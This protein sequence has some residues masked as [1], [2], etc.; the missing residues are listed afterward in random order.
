[1]CLE[2]GESHEI[3]YLSKSDVDSAFRNL[4]LAPESWPWT[5]MKARS[6]LDGQVYYFVDKCLPFGASISCALFQEVSDAV[7]HVVK[8]RTRKPLI[9]YLDDYLFVATL[10]TLCNNQM[11]E[12]L[13]VCGEIKLPILGR[14]THWAK[15][16]MTFLG[17]LI[18]GKNHLVLIPVDKIQKANDLIQVLRPGK[19]KVTIHQLQKLT[20]F[21]NFLCRCVVPGWAFT[22]RI[23]ALINP[24]LRPHHHVKII[25]EL[26]MDLRV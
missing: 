25:G 15:P 19:R 4:G 8:Q 2:C 6:P 5:V 11:T 3:I 26:R 18:D 21:L 1:M 16:L 17:F 7:A 10:R 9:N 22:R 20:G 13:T 14:K 12:F 24:K 23:Y